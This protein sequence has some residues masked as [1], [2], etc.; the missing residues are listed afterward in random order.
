MLGTRR[1]LMGKLRGLT[2][3]T[4]ALLLL[5]CG[6]DAAGSSAEAAN[7]VLTRVADS[8][9]PYPA[10]GIGGRLPCATAV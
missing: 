2:L 3:L 10:G 1:I 7:P 4:L 9:I 5:G 8:K 6:A